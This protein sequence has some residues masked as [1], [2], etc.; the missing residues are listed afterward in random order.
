MILTFHPAATAE[1]VFATDFYEAQRDGLGVAFVAAVDSALAVI[2]DHPEAFAAIVPGSPF[3]RSLV[4]RFPYSIFYSVE[5]GSI[6]VYAIAHQKRR[7]G[8]WNDRSRW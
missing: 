7:P 4:R 1:F 5:D 2:A 6:R 3:R 8:Y